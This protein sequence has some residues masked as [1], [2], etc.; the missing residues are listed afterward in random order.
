MSLEKNIQHISVIGSGN[1]AHRLSYAFLS[2]GRTID[3]IYSKTPEHAQDLLSYLR[4]YC[5]SSI[6]TACV[7]D[8]S[9]L[10]SSDLII[11]AVSDKAITFIV[12]KLIDI[13]EKDNLQNNTRNEL[14]IIVHTSGA[15]SISVLS[16]LSRFNIHYGV[17]YPLMSLNKNRI[18]DFTKVFFLL[19]GDDS[20]TE[21]ELKELIISIHSKY[22]FVTSEER[23]KMHVAAVFASNFT[24]YMLE[25][26]Y[27][28]A[29]DYAKLLLPLTIETVEK[30]FQNTPE[31]MMTGPAIRK[32]FITLEAHEK[33]LNRTGNQEAL[34]L[35]RFITNN[36]I[37]KKNNTK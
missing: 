35:Y 24:N 33:L 32:D 20:D 10:L 6:A 17:L 5:S 11:I 36:I 18:T 30:A 8:L 19:E 14:P 12:K 28:V 26:A 29:G 22:V 9:P 27:D 16:P 4:Q 2:V 25:M 7:E 21:Q 34:A 3:Y 23:L 37:N 15:T 13:L 1:M 31:K